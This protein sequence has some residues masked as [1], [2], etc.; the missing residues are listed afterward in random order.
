VADHA[1]G[2]LALQRRG[3]R[4]HRPATLFKQ[5]AAAYTGL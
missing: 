1:V 5:N 3:P 4:L 2:R